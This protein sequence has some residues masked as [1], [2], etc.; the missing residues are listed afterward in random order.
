M[1]ITKLLHMFDCTFTQQFTAGKITVYKVF[2]TVHLPLVYIQSC[3]GMMTAR[4]DLDHDMPKHIQLG[5]YMGDAYYE[6]G[7][8]ELL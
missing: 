7:T 3:Q 6:I 8:L 5:A 4:S 2:Q 1:G